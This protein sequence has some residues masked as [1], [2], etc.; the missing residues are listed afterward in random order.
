M[1][2][3]TNIV[4]QT[5]NKKEYKDVGTSPLA[6]E[7]MSKKNRPKRILNKDKRP[8][9]RR[10]RVETVLVKV[11]EEED[12][13]DILRKVKATDVDGVDAGVKSI[14]RTRCWDILMEM[15]KG[16]ANLDARNNAEEVE[17]AVKKSNEGARIRIK[18]SV[19]GGWG[20]KNPF[21]IVDPKTAR[22]AP[23]RVSSMQR[24]PPDIGSTEG[25]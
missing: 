5:E 20:Q 9:N 25:L 14:R 18:K 6:Y 7:E 21:V 15:E 4:S 24:H 2:D 10:E 23:D 19:N 22:E 16:K 12:Y 11:D 17:L 13:C 3:H 1:A 8:R